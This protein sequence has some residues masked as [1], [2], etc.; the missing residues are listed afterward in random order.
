MDQAAHTGHHQQHHGG[1]LVY[2]E[3]HIDL[4][5]PHRQP[6]PEVDDDRL[7]GGMP[8][9]LEED[10]Q[11]DQK[12]GR[13]HTDPDHRD[14]ALRRRTADRK[15]AV[16]QKAKQRKRHRKPDESSHQPLS[17]LMLRRS[18]DCL[19]R[20]MPMMIAS[21]TAASAAATVITKKTMT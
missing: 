4:Q 6:A 11:R 18:T 1:E 5:R 21:P 9:Q 10:P 17:R 13:Q 8:P 20:K 2:L 19:C 16:D 3:S 15:G 12:G 14:Q 7:L